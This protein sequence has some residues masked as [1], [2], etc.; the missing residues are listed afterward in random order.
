[1]VFPNNPSR[2]ELI[3][4]ATH[5]RR[6]HFFDSMQWLMILLTGA[7]ISLAVV[8]M[9]DRALRTHTQVEHARAMALLVLILSG[10][11]ITAILTKLKTNVSKVLSLAGVGSAFAFIGIPW[12]AR[13]IH[14]E[15]LHRDDWLIGILAG[16][17]SVVLPW[18]L[19]QVIFA[20]N[21]DGLIN[22]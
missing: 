22:R 12:I 21:G 8:L 11:S 13:L 6:S 9:Y 20:R 14:L 7:S 10:V 19:Q 17:G 16:I 18:M 2:D 15:P 3:P 4:M 5:N 1:L